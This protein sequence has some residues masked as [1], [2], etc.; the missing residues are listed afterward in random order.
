MVSS[1]IFF[2]I[3]SGRSVSWR[4]STRVVAAA[5]SALTVSISRVIRV[6]RSRPGSAKCATEVR[7]LLLELANPSASPIEIWTALLGPQSNVLVE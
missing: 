5:S 7:V 1:T 2:V 3:L 4:S 6:G